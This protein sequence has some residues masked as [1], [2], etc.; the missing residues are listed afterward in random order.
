MIYITFVKI[1][2]V[3]FKSEGVSF[4]KNASET[5]RAGTFINK[6]SKECCPGKYLGGRTGMDF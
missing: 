4:M 6:M 3:R 2:I 1:V 5:E